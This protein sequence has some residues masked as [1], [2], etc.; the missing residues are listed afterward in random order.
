MIF[1]ALSIFALSTWMVLSHRYDD[2]IIA[3][4]LLS[5]AAIVSS[6]GILDRFNTHAVITAG[7]LFFLGVLYAH[8]RPTRKPYRGFEKRS[9]PRIF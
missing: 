6:L 9:R 2:G 3:K 8:Y 5:L 4:N 1:I 7:V